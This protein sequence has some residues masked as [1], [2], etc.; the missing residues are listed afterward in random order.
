VVPRRR[1]LHGLPGLAALAGRAGV[2]ELRACRQEGEHGPSMALRRVP[3]AC[4]A[5]C[6]NDLQDTR[7]PLTVWFAAAWYM[8]ADPGGVSALTVQRLLGLGSYQTAWA[9][10]HRF[11][12]AMIRPGREVLTGRVEVD[13]TFI[14]GEQPGPPGRGALGKTLVVIAVELR[15]PRGYGRARMSNIADASAKTLREFLIGTVEPGSTVVTDG[16]SAYPAACR[17]WFVHEPRPV[18]GSGRQANELLPAVH[19]AAALCKRWLLGTHQGRVDAVGALMASGVCMIAYK[20]RSKLEDYAL[21]FAGFNAF[22]VAL[23]PNN[24]TAVLNQ[25]KSTSV[26]VGEFATRD[27]LLSNLRFVLTAFLITAVL[28]TFFDYKLMNWRALKWGKDETKFAGALA[29]VSWVTETIF[30]VLIVGNVLVG[31]ETLFG[32]TVFG[33]LHFTAAGLMI[34]NLSFAAA[35]HAF[36]ATLRNPQQN[37]DGEQT[38]SSALGGYR[39][40]VLAMWAG[41]IIGGFCIWRHVP[42]AVIV[43]E[44]VE[45]GLFVAYWLVATRRDWKNPL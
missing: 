30:L 10:L 16:W 40:I 24:F 11:R 23:V 20:G 3:E 1:G 5:H 18:A 38:S 12:T 2:P 32:G 13:E 14:G 4:L 33:I 7:T 9:M 34:G 19:R 25:A 43:T 35:S 29:V 45:I 42:Y 15:E 31:R 26:S 36:P 41:L 6:G 37:A 44:Y 28:F 17:D 39:F 21:N 22:F 27:Q 8:T